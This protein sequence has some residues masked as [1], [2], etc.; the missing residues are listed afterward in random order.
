MTGKLKI[1]KAIMQLKEIPEKAVKVS[2]DEVIL[3]EE[4]A[5]QKAA[6]APNIDADI[7][8]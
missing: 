8:S 3:G 4:K 1:P 7:D 2:P 6:A 5:E